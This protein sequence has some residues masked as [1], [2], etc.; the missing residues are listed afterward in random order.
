MSTFEVRC[1]NWYQEN[2]SQFLM[3]SGATGLELH[4]LLDR[5]EEGAR[6]LFRRAVGL[7][8]ATLELVAVEKAKAKRAAGE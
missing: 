3:D 4:R 6:V 1:W 5:L 7:I 8:H 2:V